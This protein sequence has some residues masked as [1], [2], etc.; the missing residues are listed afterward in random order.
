MRSIYKVRSN[1]K[2]HSAPRKEHGTVVH[3]WMSLPDRLASAQEAMRELAGNSAFRCPLGDAYTGPTGRGQGAG[4]DSAASP[5]ERSV[6][7]V[8]RKRRLAVLPGSGR[9][10]AA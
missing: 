9:V 6:N 5:R 4:Y 10:G 1:P 7:V 3:P 2:K 8:V